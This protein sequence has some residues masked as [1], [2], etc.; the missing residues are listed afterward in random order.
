[1]AIPDF[2]DDNWLPDGHHPATWDEIAERFGGEPGSPREYLTQNLLRFRD[3]LRSFGVSGTLIVDGSYV[4]AKPSPKDFDVLLIGQS[5]LPERKDRDPALS[6]LLDA[7]KAENEG[8]FSLFFTTTDS[9]VLDMLR[10]MWSF[11]KE[12]VSKGVLEVEI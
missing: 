4:S 2:R 6:E 3:S 11:S 7:Q 1:M 12:M 8:G 10:D 9:P 5:D